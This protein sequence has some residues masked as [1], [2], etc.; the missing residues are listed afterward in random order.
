LREARLL[1]EAGLLRTDLRSQVLQEVLP[2]GTRS[3]R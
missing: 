1:R 2:P 3:A